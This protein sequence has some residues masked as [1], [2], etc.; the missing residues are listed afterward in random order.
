[1]LSRKKVLH[2]LT[3]IPLAGALLLIMAASV[4][5]QEA[6]ENAS[7]TPKGDAVKLVVDN[8]NFWDMHM[9]VMRDGAYRSLGVV[10]GLSRTNLEIPRSLT[11]S[12]GELQILADPIG[13]RMSY[14]SGPIVLGTANEID[15]MLQ[16]DLSLSWFTLKA[17]P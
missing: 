13:E 6:P 1:M 4:S 2:G 16:S 5:A 10:S 15:L 8:N 14:F 7:Y 11:A 9:Y 17:A 3:R 12:G